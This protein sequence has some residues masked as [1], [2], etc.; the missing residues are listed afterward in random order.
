MNALSRLFLITALAGFTGCAVENEPTSSLE[1]HADITPVAR[2]SAAGQQ[3]AATVTITNR[4]G[5]PLEV[6]LSPA[7]RPA[8]VIAAGASA[9][10]RNVQ[11]DTFLSVYNAEP[12]GHE[13]DSWLRYQVNASERNHTVAVTVVDS[14][15]PGN[16]SLHLHGNGAV[17]VY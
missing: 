13:E 11:P 7:D 5:R 8:L 4:A 15:D 2:Y 9:T 14:Q 3:S 12:T 10:L 17:F 16:G 6:S 1:S